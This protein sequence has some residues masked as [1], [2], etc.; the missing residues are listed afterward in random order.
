M[1][2]A[3]AMRP[4]RF[5]TPAQSDSFQRFY[6]RFAYGGYPLFAATLVALVWAN[7]MPEAYSHTWHRELSIAWGSLSISK[8]LAFWVDEALMVLFFFTVGLEIKREFLVGQLSSFKRALLPAMAAMGGM[9]VPAL[10]YAA[11]NAGTEGAEGWAVPMATDIAFSLAILSI[12]STRVPLGIKVFLTAIAIADDLGAVIVIALFYTQS[13]AWSYLGAAALVLILLGGANRLWIR[14]TPVYVLL[15][16]ALWFCILASGVHATV[17]GVLVALFIP[18]RGRYNTEVFIQN[19]HKH[20]KHLTLDEG[21]SG[22]PTL[23]SKSHLK[24]IQ[25]ID[26]A[27][28]DVE[29]PLQRLE[30][31]MQSWI[32]M[33]V[34]PLFALANAGLSVRGIDLGAAAIHPITM[35]IM[36]GLVFGKPLGMALFAYCSVRFLGTP[37]IAGVTWRQIIGVCFLGGIGFT[38][39]LFITGLS[40]SDDQLIAYAKLGVIAGSVVSG[41][42]GF[43]LLATQRPAIR[44]G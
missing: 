36:A 40:F 24:T 31:S 25:A 22:D 29:T 8:S 12:L 26:L 30:H 18:A 15:G 27:C 23:L 2:A 43:L 5:R 17:A 14:Q 39:S 9:V 44:T 37:L 3:K 19:I 13:I 38:M 6:S 28:R 35:G 32:A 33:V 21:A 41:L 42:V 16:I 34:L 20:L 7:M 11:I 10:T 1:I 4:L